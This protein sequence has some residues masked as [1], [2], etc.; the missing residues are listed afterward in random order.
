MFLSR[1]KPSPVTVSVSA[2]ATPIGKNTNCTNCPDTPPTS[3]STVILTFFWSLC[4]LS[5]RFN[6]L[7]LCF[8]K[9]ETH[10]TL[11]PWRSDL[12]SFFFFRVKS[13]L[14]DISEY[15][16]M[17]W[18]KLWFKL[19]SVD[20]SRTFHIVLGNKNKKNLLDSFREASCLVCFYAS[21]GG[22]R[23]LSPCPSEELCLH[24][25]LFFWMNIFCRK[26]S[27]H[28]SSNPVISALCAPLTQEDFRIPEKFRWRWVVREQ[29]THACTDFFFFFACMDSV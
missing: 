4:F 3:L 9:K 22:W 18:C 23:L 11:E 15:D 26:A 7:L 24:S 19:S 20:T 16:D 1:L 10:Q 5:N 27:R 21:S 6:E 29:I 25:I 8:F 14:K 28:T 2:V 17:S 12:C 13:T